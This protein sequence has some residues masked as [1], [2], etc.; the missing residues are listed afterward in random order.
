M[1]FASV[2]I[3]QLTCEPIVHICM[4]QVKHKESILHGCVV[5]LSKIEI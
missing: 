4:V 1:H 2:N 3:H 5:K